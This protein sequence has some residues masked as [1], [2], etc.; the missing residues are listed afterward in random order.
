MTASPKPE[1]LAIGLR[2]LDFERAFH[3]QVRLRDACIQSGGRP[4]YLLLLEHPPT[5]TVGRSGDSGDVVAGPQLL[6]ARGWAVVETNRGG[7]A[8]YHGPGQLV[9]YPI[10]HL[11][12]RG[13]DLHR[14]LRDL[15]R[16][17]VRLCRGFGVPAHADHPLTGVWVEDRKIASIGIAVRRWVT[18]HGVALNVSTDLRAFAAI[19]PCGLREVTM[20]SLERELGAA[21]PLEEVTEAAAREFAETFRME[22]RPAT[23]EKVGA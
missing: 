5:V 6:A 21:P 8:T 12:S 10:V 23:A 18:Y 16:W 20:T 14:Y 13:R 17:L 22:L 1:L 15:E 2:R 9:G 7:R 19:V 4:N 11:G 3:L